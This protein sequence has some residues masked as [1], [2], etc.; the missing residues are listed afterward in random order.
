MITVL[1]IALVTLV[2]LALAVSLVIVWAVNK[3]VSHNDYTGQRL[4][5]ELIQ[6]QR[7][8]RKM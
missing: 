3:I 6:I 8:T 2:V 1:V 4:E 5:S 7:N